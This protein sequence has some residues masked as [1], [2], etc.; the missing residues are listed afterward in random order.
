MAIY[1]LDDRVPDFIPARGSPTRDRDRDVEL[2]E[3][4]TPGSIPRGDTALLR[5]GRRSV[6]WTAA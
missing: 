3:D 1:R 2:G 4:A 5:I 6:L